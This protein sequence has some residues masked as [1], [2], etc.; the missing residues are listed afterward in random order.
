MARI[1]VDGTVSAYLA[2]Q[3]RDAA[4]WMADYLGIDAD[5][6]I[7][8]KLN[9]RRS[10]WSV[11][12]NQKGWCEVEIAT[13][14]H[15]ATLETMI[16]LPILAHEL[17]HARQYQQGQLVTRAW[18]RAGWASSWAGDPRWGSAGEYI[19]GSG[20]GC[21]RYRDLPWE[22]EAYGIQN[23]VAGAFRRRGDTLAQLRTVL[24]E[25]ARATG[26]PG[27]GEVPLVALLEGGL[28]ATWASP[29]A[30]LPGGE[31]QRVAAGAGWHVVG[32]HR[33]SHVVLRAGQ[34]ISG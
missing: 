3:V 1:S 6:V 5:Y 31:A 20:A 26:T 2:Q 34:R 30:W 15:A 32:F 13:D 24:A 7:K 25:K 22:R 4:R 8:I 11:A 28:P 14:T 19:K 16:S 18:S 33:R 9:G 21:T 29:G 12:R 27:T 23:E 17:V 10:R